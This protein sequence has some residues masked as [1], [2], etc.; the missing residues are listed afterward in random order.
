MVGIMALLANL[1]QAVTGKELRQLRV[2]VPAVL[3]M[4]GQ[5]TML[6]IARWSGKGGSYPTVRRFYEASIVWLKVNWALS[7]K[8]L[9]EMGGIFLLVGDETVA[10]KSGKATYGIDRFFSSIYKRPVP[11]VAFFGVSLVSVTEQHATML[12]LEQLKKAEST[13]AQSRPAKAKGKKTKPTKQETKPKG[14]RRKGSKNK[15]RRDI[16]LPAYLQK[17][18]GYFQQ[19]LD[20]I[21]NQ[22]SI[23]YCLLDGAFGNNHALQMVRRLGLHLISKLAKNSALYFPYTGE[24]KKRGNRRKYGAKLDYQAI[25]ERY[26]KKRTSAEGVC[27]E[28]YQMPLWSHAFPD[29]L[30]IVVIVKTKLATQ[31]RAHVVL[32]SSD[33]AL[34]A[35][36]LVLYYRLRF[37]IEFNFRDAKQYWGLE[38]FMNINQRPVYNAANFALFLT[39]L[40]GWLVRQRRATVPDFSVADLKAEFRGRFYALETLKLFPDSPDQGFIDR[41]I[42]RFSSIGAVNC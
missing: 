10:T 36:Q 18:Q 32:F 3:A 30:N 26:L 19:V 33:L 23:P 2:I 5:V 8:Q 29:L 16:E 42:A 28:I 17:L 31:Q 21:G 25:P 40:A 9:Q 27:T 38:D 12:L 34:E 24:Q 37:Q 20:V 39:N 15:N 7:H 6:N 22:L 11:G 13:S 35:A 1:S 14:G 4:T 41:L